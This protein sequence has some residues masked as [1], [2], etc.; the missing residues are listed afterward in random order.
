MRNYLIILFYCCHFFGLGQAIQFTDKEKNWIKN[1]PVIEY[2]Y[3]P[4]WEPY[5]VY[6]NGEYGG[7]I[8]EYVKIIEDETGIDLRPIP[9][10][11]W[12]ESMKGL[13]N[14]SIMVVPSLVATPERR[15]WLALTDPYIIDPIVIL[16]REDA[17]YFSTLEDLSD[18]SI[19][20]S[21]NYYTLELIKESF[22]K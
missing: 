3:E 7:I 21:K 10:L 11:T 14:G 13:V 5:E 4:R 19:A 17:P 8:G 6:S 9:N 1:H 15:E 20:L 16:A 2:G 12:D 22:Q 18:Q